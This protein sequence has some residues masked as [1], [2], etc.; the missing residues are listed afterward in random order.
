MENDDAMRITGAKLICVKCGRAVPKA[1]KT[2]TFYQGYHCSNCTGHGGV[3][4]YGRDS[5]G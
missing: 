3:E 5:M 2:G 1:E 4:Y